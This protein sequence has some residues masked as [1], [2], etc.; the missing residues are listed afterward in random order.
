MFVGLSAALMLFVPPA[1]ADTIY[2][3]TDENGVK[4][5]SNSQPPEDVDQVNTI[6][7]IQYDDTS[8]KQ[9]REAYD[10]MVNDAA[11]EAD[12]HFEENAQKE[13]QRIEAERQ[14]EQDAY[15]QRIA[16]ERARLLKEIEEL[17]SR[18][19]GPTFTKGMQDNQIRRIQEQLDQ[20]KP[21]MEGT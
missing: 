13:A 15:N 5:Y 14:K 2:I 3:W 8:D 1:Y 20:L 19:Y 6:E 18:G 4:H 9:Y 7:G 10:R 16:A 21:I 12:R 17:K 11:R